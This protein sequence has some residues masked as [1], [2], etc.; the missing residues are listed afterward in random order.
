MAQKEQANNASPVKAILIVFRTKLTCTTGQLSAAGY[1]GGVVMIWGRGVKPSGLLPGFC[2]A[3]LTCF[4]F[5]AA[6]GFHWKEAV[7]GYH[8]SFPRDHFNH[9][10]FRTEWWYYTGNVSD[11]SGAR[12]GFELVF[13]R[14]GQK[15]D[16]QGN[17]SA[18]RVDD[19]FL[20]HTALTDISGKRFLYQERLNRAGPGIAGIDIEGRRVWNGNWSATWSGEKQTLRAVAPEFAFTLD[21]EPS[22]PAIINGVEG[23]SQ[24]AEGRGKASYYVSFPRLA[25]RGEIALSG[26]KHTVSGTAWMDH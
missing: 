10:D 5:A 17:Q 14:Q 23:V 2:P 18:W 20:A 1:T 21:A 8:F 22:K 19:M 16:V 15:R 6:P 11:A 12:F 3:F 9:P 13:F 24:K 4:L 26:T 25:V 7:P